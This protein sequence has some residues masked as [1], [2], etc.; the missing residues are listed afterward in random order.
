MTSPHAA[1]AVTAPVAVLAILNA[2]LFAI[3]AMLHV[4]VAIGPIAEPVSVPAMMLEVVTT[5]VLALA[6]MGIFTAASW[7]RRLASFS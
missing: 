7:A 4:G 3:G 5:I 2:A 6:T 1:P